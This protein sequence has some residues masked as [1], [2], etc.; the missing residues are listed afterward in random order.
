M[1]SLPSKPLSSIDWLFCSPLR[2]APDPFLCCLSQSLAAF[3][4]H[5]Y[6]LIKTDSIDP[7]QS[8]KFLLI[9]DLEA[10]AR[11]HCS[12]ISYN[13]A[14]EG[15]LPMEDNADLHLWNSYCPHRAICCLQRKPE[16]FCG[17]KVAFLG[18]A[19]SFFSYMSFLRKFVGL[20]CLWL[21]KWTLSSN[22]D[23]VMFY[24]KSYFL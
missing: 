1:F 17:E 12:T 24:I 15:R 8:F 10:Q 6:L 3:D 16:G 21:S 5:Y 7:A 13:H 9:K 18:P 23:K 19:C 4:T 14:Y 22:R 20:K 2:L 11:L